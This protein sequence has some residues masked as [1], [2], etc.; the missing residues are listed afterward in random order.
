MQFAYFCRYTFGKPV[1]GIVD[2]L[3]RPKNEIFQW[4]NGS[5][6][7]VSKVINLQMPV[8]QLTLHFYYKKNIY[9]II[10]AENKQLNKISLN[11]NDAS[12]V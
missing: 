6:Q 3:I 11:K 10:R 12:K 5:R 4:I 7:R 1:K 2:I 8:S 9:T